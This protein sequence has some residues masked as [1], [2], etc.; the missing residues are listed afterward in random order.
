MT[1]QS[2]RPAN[3]AAAEQIPAAPASANTSASFWQLPASTVLIASIALALMMSTQFLFQPFVWRNWPW[4]EVLAGWLEFAQEQ[5]VAALAI[6]GAV[7]CANRIPARSLGSRSAVLGVA[8]LTGAVV[9]ELALAALALPGAARDAVTLLGRTAR[10]GLVGSSVAAMWHLWRRS[11][12]ASAIARA[13]E[14]RRAQLQR[15]AAQVRLSALRSQIEPHF[16]FNTLATVRRLQ[17]IE[18]EQG[19]RLLS[20]FVDYLRSAQPGGQSDGET[21]TLSQEVE[22]TRAYLGVI[23]VRMAGRLAV[24]FDVDADLHEHPFPPLTISTLAE[25]AVKHGIAPAPAGG[26]IVVSVRRVGEAIEAAVSDTGVGFSG[27][28]GSGIGLA[29]IRARLHTLFGDAGTL[30][31]RSNLPSGVRA[32]IRLPCGHRL[33][34]PL[35]PSAVPGAKP[36]VHGT[37][38][39]DDVLRAMRRL[40]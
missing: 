18:P 39:A 21:N 24:S 16:L 29:N 13:I 35:E 36:N 27:S 15:Q 28:G 38:N 9:G 20:H 37:P 40:R 3:L 14:L 34:A 8:I 22:L 32:T 5:V 4:D 2:P 6:A 10:W 19:A 17:Q 26:A 23:A 31:L 25:N 30:T 1:R 12:E 33:R 11:A 7:L